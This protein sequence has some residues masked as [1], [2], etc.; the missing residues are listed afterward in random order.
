MSV[1]GLRRFAAASVLPVGLMAPSAEMIWSQD[2]APAPRSSRFEAARGTETSAVQRIPAG[3]AAPTPAPGT[4]SLNRAQRRDL[5]QARRRSTDLADQSASAFERGLMP[6]T[7][8][9]EQETLVQWTEQLLTDVRFDG[10]PVAVRRKHLARMQSALDQLRQFKQPNAKRWEADVALAEWAVADAE[11][12]LAREG[13]NTIATGRAALRRSEASREHSRLRQRDADIGWASLEATSLASSL[14][15][16]SA[17]PDETG[18]AESA[19]D[20]RT[21]LALVAERTADW[22]RDGAGVG[23]A[24]R[25]QKSE[26]AVDLVDLTA[27]LQADRK[28]QA[29][30]SMRRADQ[31]LRELFAT[32]QEFYGKGTASLYDLSRTW[33]AWRELHQMGADKPGLVDSEQLAE[34]QQSRATLSGLADQTLDQR[35]RHAADITVVRL[36][37]QMDG[38]EVLR[39]P[40]IQSGE[41]L[42]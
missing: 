40:A 12:Q 3:E 10:S 1:R 6:F 11:L 26:L 30:Q 4:I 23:R 22:S 5:E 37:E 33:L 7:V 20:H 24:D 15:V 19:A 31:R 17:L 28:D 2:V 42:K 36:L 29:K 8:Y 34:R 39:R 27:D 13:Q 35:G 21:Y 9:L 32:Q 25:V 14:T 16:S 38:L 41:Y 18:R